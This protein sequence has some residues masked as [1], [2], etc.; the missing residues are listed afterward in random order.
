MTYACKRLAERIQA[1]AVL[2]RARGSTANRVPDLRCTGSANAARGC[3]RT[4]AG[5]VELQSAEIQQGTRLSLRVGESILVAA[6]AEV[7]GMVSFPEPTHMLTGLPEVG[8]VVE[9][10]SEVGLAKAK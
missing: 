5:R 2:M 7:A 1:N 3:V 8:E 4:Q 10:V 9:V 6:S